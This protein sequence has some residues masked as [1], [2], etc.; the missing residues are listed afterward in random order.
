MTPT[1]ALA[2]AAACGPPV[3]TRTGLHGVHK[4]HFAWQVGGDEPGPTSSNLLFNFASL[5]REFL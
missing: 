3:A 5:N 2:A 1:T 4:P